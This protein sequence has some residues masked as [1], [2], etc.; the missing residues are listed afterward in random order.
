MS[1]RTAEITDRLRQSEERT[2]RR[3]PRLLTSAALL[4]IPWIGVLILQID[5]R[6]G[7]RDF[8]NS[9]IGL[10]LFEVVALLSLAAL[11]RRRHRGSS[12]LAAA[13]SVLFALDAY[14]DVMSA[15]PRLD[16]FF[17]SVLAYVAELP[18]ALLLA[19]LSWYTLRWA[20][21]P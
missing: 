16:Y 7:A 3:L 18:I 11:V 5:G 2:V 10:D 15:A 9:W 8:A 20:A 14:F 1:L 4:L 13:T 17:A 19:W 6:V 21:Q 12:P